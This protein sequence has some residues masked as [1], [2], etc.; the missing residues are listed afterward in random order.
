MG[1]HDISPHSATGGHSCFLTLTR[2]KL[3]LEYADCVVRAPVAS[4]KRNGLHDLPAPLLQ[5]TQL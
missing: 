1:N 5:P 4:S 2:R 3:V